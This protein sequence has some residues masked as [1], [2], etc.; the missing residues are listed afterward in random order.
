MQGFLLNRPLRAA[1]LLAFLRAGADR[2]V[3]TGSACPMPAG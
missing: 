1:D 2:I 3:A